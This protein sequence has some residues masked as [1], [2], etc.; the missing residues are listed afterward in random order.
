MYH[1]P[2]VTPE[3][4]S[5][6]YAFGGRKPRAT[7]VYGQ[8]E[9]RIAYEKLNS[10]A[11]SNDVDFIMLG[12]PHNSIEQVGLAARLLDGKRLSANTS[13]WVFTPRALKEVADRSGYTGIIEAAG[14]HVLT[15]TCP[16]ISRIMPKNTKVVATDSAKQAHYLPAITGVQAWFG[17]VADCVEAAVSGRWN[18]RL[19]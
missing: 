2:G 1:I 6:E 16:A 5:E 8:A 13:L 10:T 4:R 14:G 17:S 19:A 11:K 18:G 15:D 12:C 3:T 9:R 7:F